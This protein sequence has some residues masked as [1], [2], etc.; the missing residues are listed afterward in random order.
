MPPAVEAWSPTTGP[1]GKSLYILFHILF[2]YSLLDIISTPTLTFLK[3]PNL[4]WLEFEIN[5]YDLIP[6]T[7]HII[8]SV[9]LAIQ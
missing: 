6:F 4:L 2:H 8:P 9:T 3:L 5:F 7:S 1:P